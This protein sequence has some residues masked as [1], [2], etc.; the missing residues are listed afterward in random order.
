MHIS[1]DPFSYG[2]VIDANGGATLAIANVM[3]FRGAGLR[4][5]Q[6]RDEKLMFGLSARLVELFAIGFTEEF[7]GLGLGTSRFE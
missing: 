1:R 2:A 7:R 3:K 5:K 6:D 4:S